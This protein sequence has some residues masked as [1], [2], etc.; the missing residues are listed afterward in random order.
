VHGDYVHLQ[1][2]PQYYD[3][4]L[5]RCERLEQQIQIGSSGGTLQLMRFELGDI[6]L[7]SLEDTP[8]PDY[9]R[10]RRAPQWQPNILHAPMMDVRY[11]CMNTELKPFDN[12]LVRQAVNYAINKERI[13]AT[14]AGRVQAARGVLPPGMP[15]YNAR[16]KSYDYDPDKARALLKQAGYQDD[17][18]HPVALWYADML[19]YPYAAQSIQQDLKQV[20]MTINLKS[21][22]YPE[23]KAA[24]GRRKNVPLSIMG[25]LQDFPDPANFLDVLF[26]GKSITPTAS[27]NRSFYSNPQVN[28]LLDAAGVELDRARRMK[29]YQEAEQMIVND[30]PIVPLVH[31]ERYVAHQPW[32]KGYKLHPMWSSRYE[33]VKVER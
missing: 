14:L 33:Y 16:L 26:N 31:T 25:W 3:K 13:V 17:P 11:L 29:M 6:D 24:G 21:M 19:W 20:S 12:K 32:I 8:T 9:L 5:P 18:A 7:Y 22:T 27:L 23:L 10:L 4:N 30:A 15:A 28:A 1:K 2:N